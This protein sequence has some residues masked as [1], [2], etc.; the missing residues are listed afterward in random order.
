MQD[1]RIVVFVESDV[2]E[3]VAVQ[4][5]MLDPVTEVMSKKQRTSTLV[6]GA[7]STQSAEVE[8]SHV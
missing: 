3:R 2:L 7:I 4:W 6:M 1:Q 8:I 5:L